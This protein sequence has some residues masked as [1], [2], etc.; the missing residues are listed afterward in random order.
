MQDLFCKV[1]AYLQSLNY[2]Q[3][4]NHF[5]EPLPQSEIHSIAR[6]VTKWVW[7][8]RDRFMRRRT[9]S[10]GTMGFPPMRG[11]SKRE[12]LLELKRRQ[13]LSGFRTSR[14]RRER[15]YEVLL[16]TYSRIL[17]TNER[18]TQRLVSEQSG[19]SLRTVKYYWPLIVQG[20]NR[21][22]QWNRAEE[23]PV[24]T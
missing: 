4:L 3:L 7:E 22:I 2:G 1:L 9:W 10:D 16:S 18:V 17:S 12:Y 8:G 24:K 23:A 5:S 19:N 21:S 14:M 20:A 6:S 15:T 13:R 11:L